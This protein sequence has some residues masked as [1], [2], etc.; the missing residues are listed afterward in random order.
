MPMVPSGV[1]H[2]VQI[3]ER[4]D[5]MRGEQVQT[6]GDGRPVM[7]VIT[8]RDDGQDCAVYAPVAQGKRSES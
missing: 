1:K 4:Q 6:D 5:Y 7:A 8:T 3:V 2:K